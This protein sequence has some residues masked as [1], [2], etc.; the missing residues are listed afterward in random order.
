MGHYLSEMVGPPFTT[1]VEFPLND[2]SKSRIKER[3]LADKE[4]DLD[5]TLNYQTITEDNGRKW[6][7]LHYSFSGSRCF[8]SLESSDI[9]DIIGV[10][11]LFKIGRELERKRRS[12]IDRAYSLYLTQ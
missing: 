6:F 8:M 3:F 10:F 11:P 9:Q 5:I 7:E 1:S 12:A 2:D 4:G